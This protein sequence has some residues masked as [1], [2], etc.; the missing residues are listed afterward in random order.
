MTSVI[1]KRV[2][3]FEKI[4]VTK[5][6]DEDAECSNCRNGYGDTKYWY[7]VEQKNHGGLQLCESCFLKLKEVKK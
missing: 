3:S 5:K 4:R 7:V 1:I 2:V 6:N